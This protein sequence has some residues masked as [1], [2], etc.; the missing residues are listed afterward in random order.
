[1]VMPET[2]LMLI[3]INIACEMKRRG[4]PDGKIQVVLAEAADKFWTERA[5]DFVQ[6]RD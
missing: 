1:M 5:N 6:T 4:I 3:Q 2:L